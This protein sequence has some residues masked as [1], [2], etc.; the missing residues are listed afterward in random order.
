MVKVSYRQKPY[1]RSMM[2][3][4]GAEVFA[5]PTDLTRAGRAILE[6]DPGSDG[7]LGVAI[8]EAVEDA[9]L[10]DDTKYALG[11]VL[12]HVCMHQTVIGQEAQG[13][14]HVTK[15]PGRQGLV[16]RS[17]TQRQPELDGFS[18]TPPAR[19]ARRAPPFRSSPPRNRCPS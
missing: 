15:S 13:N 18:D 12:N 16:R 10:H 17:W 14:T 3:A 5:S 1:R 11:S 19:A 9:M 4:W 2:Q 6:R 8:S 7:S